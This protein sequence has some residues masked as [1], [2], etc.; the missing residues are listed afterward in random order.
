M[1]MGN[2]LP[3]DRLPKGASGKPLTSVAATGTVSAFE[4]G[5]SRKAG[6]LLLSGCKEGPNN[7]SYD[8]KIKGRPTGAFTYYALKALE[9]LQPNATYADWQ[10]AINP[11]YL[12]SASYPQSPQ[13]VGNAVARNRK[14]FT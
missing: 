14:I 2:W 6:D 13:I 10:A 11:Q 3:A 8:A 12:P 9:D 1:P 5:L 4:R 7:F